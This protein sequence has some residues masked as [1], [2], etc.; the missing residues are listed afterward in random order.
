MAEL[1]VSYLG[2]DERGVSQQASHHAMPG[3]FPRIVRRRICEDDQKAE[4]LDAVGLL[5]GQ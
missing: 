2:I 1:K 5:A 4:V 3:K